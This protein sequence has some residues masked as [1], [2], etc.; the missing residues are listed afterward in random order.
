MHGPRAIVFRAAEEV[1]RILRQA[2]YTFAIIGSTACYLYGNERRPNDIDIVISSHACDLEFLKSLVAIYNPVNFGLV[3]AK[4][5]GATRQVLWYQD[6][7]DG[8]LEK[9]KVDILKPG[10][11]NLPMI[12]SEAIVDKQGL[13]VVP[14]SILLLHKLQ[15]WKDNMDSD[16][17]RLRNKCDADAGD[18]FSLLEIIIESMG[19]KERQNSVHWKQFALDRFDE[20]FRGNTERRV[21]L[22]CSIYPQ[23]R[24]MWKKLGW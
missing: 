2:G 7:V 17:P 12:F 9:T 22:F 20:E 18:I 13:P 3:D 24:E 6:Y 16:I 8:R 14:M 4:T 19:L 5:P 1:T 23:Y 21:R 11:L 15:G 10:I